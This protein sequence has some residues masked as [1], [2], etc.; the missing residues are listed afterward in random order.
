MK[1]EIDR[2]PVTN[3]DPRPFF[4]LRLYPETN[5]EMGLM[6]WGIECVP[7]PKEMIRVFNGRG[8]KTFHY[9]IIFERKDIG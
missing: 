8:D 2:R 5:E 6:E 4:A 1:I 7:K 3:N 9:A